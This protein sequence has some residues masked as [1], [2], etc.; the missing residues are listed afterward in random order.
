MINAYLSAWPVNNTQYLVA[1][2]IITIKS[3]GQTAELDR[4]I[5]LLSHLNYSP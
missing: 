4:L 1:N 2:I 3:Q 5:I